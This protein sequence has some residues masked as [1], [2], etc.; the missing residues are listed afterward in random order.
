MPVIMH[1]ILSFM[2]GIS[3]NLKEVEKSA[4]AQKVEQ[5]KEEPA[6]VA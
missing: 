2:K 6:K 5:P 1:L 4:P 3:T